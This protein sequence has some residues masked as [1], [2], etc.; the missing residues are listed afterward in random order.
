MEKNK[1][2]RTNILRILS[3]ITV[4]YPFVGY[5]VLLGILIHNIY[6][7]KASVVVASFCILWGIIDFVLNTLALFLL[8]VRG[9]TDLPVC[10]LSLII[11]KCPGLHL[12]EDIGEAMDVMLSFC[13]VS[14]GVGGNLLGYLDGAQL[15]I[16]GFCTVFNLTGAGIFRLNSSITNNRNP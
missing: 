13:I 15:N 14:Y 1:N 7:G 9:K 10:L 2:L 16:W 3:V 12:W 4:G 11:R 6:G 8:I 5:K